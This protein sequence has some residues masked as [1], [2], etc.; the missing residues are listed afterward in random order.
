M[1]KLKWKKFQK[2]KFK[3]HIQTTCTSADMG[4]NVQ[5]FKK[6]G[7]KLYEKLQSQGTLRLYI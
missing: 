1:T 5:S 2:N 4:E 3:N 7:L 6:T